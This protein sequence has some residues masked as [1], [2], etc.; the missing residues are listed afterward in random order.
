VNPT[1]EH[2]QIGAVRISVADAV[3]RAV[4]R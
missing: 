1:R 4:A 2:R 3:M